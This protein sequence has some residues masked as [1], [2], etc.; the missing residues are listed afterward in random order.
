MARSSNFFPALSSSRI[1][2]ILALASSSVS[3]LSPAPGLPLTATRICRAVNFS[4]VEKR[5]LLALK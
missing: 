5:S 4:G 1:L 3:P 2:V